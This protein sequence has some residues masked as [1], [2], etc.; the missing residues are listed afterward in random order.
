MRKFIVYS[1]NTEKSIYF[2]NML[3]ST[4][5]AFQTVF[6]LVFISR[7]DPIVDAGI[8]TIAFA[9]GN[10][11]LTLAN[12]GVRQFQVSDVKKKYSFRDYLMARGITCCLMIGISIIYVTY[13]KGTGLYNNYK[14]IVILLICAAKA[15][16]AL[17]DVVLG[18]FQKEGRLDIAGKIMTIRLSAYI[19]IYITSYLIS[20]NLIISSTCALLVSGVLF[21]VLNGYAYVNFPEKKE[22][23]GLRDKRQ[24]KQVF[25]LLKECFPLFVSAYLVMYISNAPKYAIDKVLSNQEQACFTYIFMPVFV[26]GMLS[27]FVFQPI[28]GKLSN[29][30]DEQNIFELK[31]QVYKQLGIILILSLCALIVG[32]MF[33]IPVLSL[34]YGVD[35]KEYQIHLIVLLLGGVFLAYNY[36]FQMLLT[37]IRNQKY[38][39]WGYV[40]AYICFLMFGTGVVEKNGLIGISFFYTFIM[41]GIMLYFSTI[42][43]RIINK[44]IVVDN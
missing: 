7:I 42:S 38:L 37:I 33:G 19:I 6:V 4:L 2:W 43:M 27:Q 14:S 10:L 5:N 1:R 25:K 39:V 26:V 13:Y 35:L 8:F 41:A 36:F 3:A 20:R 23:F 32:T 21:I 34:L 22:L 40:V 15:I 11:M 16:D 9:I 28:I 44:N 12:Y 29:L 17:E 18:L 31:K 24:E 30:W